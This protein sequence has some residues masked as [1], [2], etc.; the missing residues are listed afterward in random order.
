MYLDD[1]EERQQVTGCRCAIVP[2]GQVP[3]ART[4]A[5]PI[6]PVRP[7]R[8]TLAAAGMRSPL[9]CGRPALRSDRDGPLGPR[10]CPRLTTRLSIS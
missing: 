3:A 6:R 2:G 4:L 7:V 1:L 8:P 5:T 10:L 9:V